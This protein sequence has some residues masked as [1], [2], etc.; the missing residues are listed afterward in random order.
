[1]FCTKWIVSLSLSFYLFLSHTHRGKSPSDRTNPSSSKY[2]NLDR[3]H[4][5][6]DIDPS[7]RPQGEL[8]GLFKSVE[9]NGT[10]LTINCEN[11]DTLV[12]KMNDGS[13]PAAKRAAD[14][15]KMLRAFSA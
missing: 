12:M 3:V 1:M 7:L 14:W 9:V 13:P 4:A 15:V 2:L 8:K 6:D 10:T 11:G 5:I